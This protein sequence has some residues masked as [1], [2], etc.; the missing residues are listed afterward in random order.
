MLR[1]KAHF[2]PVPSVLVSPVPF[3]DQLSTVW[4]CVLAGTGQSNLTRVHLGLL[5]MGAV[6]LQGLNDLHIQPLH[7]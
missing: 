4:S 6:E 5:Q 3:P 2:R 1:D 7:L